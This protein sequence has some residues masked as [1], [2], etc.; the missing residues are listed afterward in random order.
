MRKIIIMLRPLFGPG[1][2]LEGLKRGL[3]SA[4]SNYHPLWYSCLCTLCFDLLLP[5][6]IQS[7]HL[8]G[9]DYFWVL[10]RAQSNWCVCFWVYEPTRALLL[11]GLCVRMSNECLSVVVRFLMACDICPSVLLLSVSVAHLNIHHRCNHDCPFVFYSSQMHVCQCPII[12]CVSMTW[13]V[14]DV[15][16]GRVMAGFRKSPR[17]LPPSMDLDATWSM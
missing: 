10:S 13:K 12:R 8:A 4:F 5:Y 9:Y 3:F 16:F 11:F 6:V 1:L 2:F 15:W 7:K 17:C 14:R